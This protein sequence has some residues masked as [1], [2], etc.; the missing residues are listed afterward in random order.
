MSLA[1]MLVISCR[2]WVVFGRMLVIVDWAF[3]G[4]G[5]DLG[6]SGR[7]LMVLGWIC[8][9]AVRVLLMSARVL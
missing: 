4:F 8:C 5:Q 2:I 9:D 7:D 3:T 1:R 6:D